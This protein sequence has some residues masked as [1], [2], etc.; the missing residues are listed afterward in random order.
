MASGDD[1]DLLGR[2]RAARRLDARDGAGGVAADRGRLAILDDVD[3]ARRGRAR[4][5]PGDRVVPRCAASPLQ[6]RADDRIADVA[7][8]VEK[9]AE[10]LGLFGDSHSLSTPARRLAWTWRLPTWTSWVLCASIMTPRGE[11]MTL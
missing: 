3:A 9:R 7:S 1:A 6:R 2:D 8:D 4:I 5:A 10:G 11:Y